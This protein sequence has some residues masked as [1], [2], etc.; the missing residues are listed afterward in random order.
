M[1]FHVKMDVC[2]PHDMPTEQWL[3]A[4]NAAIAAIRKA[5][6]HNLILVP[7]NSWTGAHSWLDDWYGGPNGVWMLKVRDPQDHYAFEVHQYLDADS[8]GTK[9]TVRWL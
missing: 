9:T 4:A 2:L 5:G 3:G 8:S 1:L 6:A 7:G